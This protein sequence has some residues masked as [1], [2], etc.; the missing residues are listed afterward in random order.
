MKTALPW[1]LVVA[2]LGG[3]IFLYSG[4][5]SSDAALEKLRQ[6]NQQLESLR[7]ENE[8][9]NTKVTDQG[10]EIAR[11]Q[12]DNEEVL[13]LRSE[14]G[15][16]R[17]QNQQLTK[18]LQ[19]AQAQNGQMQQQ[20]QQTAAQMDALR[21]QTQ[22]MQQTQAQAQ[23]EQCL[24]NLRMIDGAKQQWALEYKK[25]AGSI[26]TATDI[27]PYLPN[28]TLPT[29]PGGGTYSINALNLL[30]TCTIAGHVLPRL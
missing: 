30:P 23:A 26:P 9:L 20:Q 25:A 5:S 19:T 8:Q 22:Q 28:N 18:Q 13:R 1:V 12:K 10:A 27:A 29:C 11:L 15:Q 14:A 21:N 2:L 17:S 6:D 7:A 24:N 4:K 16:L 3:V